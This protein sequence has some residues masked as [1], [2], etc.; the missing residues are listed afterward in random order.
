MNPIALR[1][2]AT[3]ALSLAAFAVPA[4]SLAADLSGR[5]DRLAVMVSGSTI[6]NDFISD[7]GWG[8][9]ALWLHNFNANVVL[10][11]GG[12]HQ[13]LSDADWNFGIVSFNYGFGPAGRRT[14]VYVD[15]RQGSGEDLTHSYDYGIYTAGL[16]QSLT[17][18]LTLQLEDKQVDVDTVRG[19]LPKLGLS[20]LWSSEA[21]HRG[22][23]SAFRERHARHTHHHFAHRQLSRRH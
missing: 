12:E 7:N 16:Y 19:N 14:N 1:T 15:G 10:G 23:V 5:D 17:K 6:E 11:V 2:L 13:T 9:S 8:A 4:P 21:R 3:A 22:L 18:Q 20:Y